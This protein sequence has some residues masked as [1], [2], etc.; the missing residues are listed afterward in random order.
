MIDEDFQYQENSI[1][2]IL[3]FPSE[4][5]NSPTKDELFTPLPIEDF[6]LNLPP[7]DLQDNMMPDFSEDES[8]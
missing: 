4:T 1:D 7:I 8:S 2:L 5:D 6:K 3:K